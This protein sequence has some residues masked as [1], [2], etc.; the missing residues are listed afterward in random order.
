MR[1]LIDGASTRSFI[2]TACAKLLGL[3]TFDANVSICGLA[4]ASLGVAHKRIC[5]KFQLID[6]I[7]WRVEA[8][9]IDEITRPPSIKVNLKSW[10]HLHGLTLAYMLLLNW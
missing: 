8:L 10:D 9:I 6:S 1:M 5:C 2:T 7:R 4:H 3:V